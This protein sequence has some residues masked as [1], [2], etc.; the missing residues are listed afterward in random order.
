[1]PDNQ[2]DFGRQLRQQTFLVVLA[3]LA[4]SKNPITLAGNSSKLADGLRIDDEMRFTETVSL[5]WD[6]AGKTPETVRLPVLPLQP[7]VR[8]P[9]AWTNPRPTRSS[10]SSKAGRTPLSSGP[11]VHSPSRR[12]PT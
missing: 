7:A 8:R 12:L 5:G 9:S 10:P 2:N 6:I 4:S 3:K 1:M 11:P